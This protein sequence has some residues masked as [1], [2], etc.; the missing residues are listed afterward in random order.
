MQQRS[1]RPAS[2][3]RTEEPSPP[4][5]RSAL[6]E[7]VDGTVRAAPRQLELRS[8]RRVRDESDASGEQLRITSPEGRLELE[9]RFNAEGPV[10]RFGRAAVELSSE[11][12]VT[13]GARNLH[14]RAAEEL[15]A[16]GHAV[17][18]RSRRGDVAIRAND[19]V[20]LDGERIKLN[21]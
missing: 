12:D 17:R 16:E 7:V 4:A 21:S 13:L 8:G 10:L 20:R 2:S 19:D 11:G 6:E 15:S 9:V 3:G 1:D 18:L 5:S 14:L